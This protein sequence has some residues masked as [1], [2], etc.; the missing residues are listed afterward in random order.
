MNDTTETESPELLP[1][2]AELLARFA[3]IL[4]RDAEAAGAGAKIKVETRASHLAHEP[5]VRGVPQG[6][7][8]VAT[9]AAKLRYRGSRNE[10]LSAEDY[11]GVVS[12]A[13]GKPVR[14]ETICLP[15][16]GEPCKACQATG[17]ITHGKRDAHGVILAG[18]ARKVQCKHCNGKGRHAPTTHTAIVGE[19]CTMGRTTDDFRVSADYAA[20]FGRSYL[21]GKEKQ[22]P[23][24]LT[25]LGEARRWWETS[26]ETRFYA[27]EKIDTHPYVVKLGERIIG[28]F[29]RREHAART[30][31]SM[32]PKATLWHVGLTYRKIG[33]MD[34]LISAAGRPEHGSKVLSHR[35]VTGMS[36]QR[37]A[38]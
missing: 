2:E 11:R 16:V 36:E 8:T 20:W 25:G 35:T 23:I 30:V 13:T 33:Y 5:G 7:V 17:T 28:M 32:G 4:K 22:G 10:R 34:Q 18:K 31:A 12:A 14:T 15:S 3:A 1:G 9:E 29:A 37:I 24:A 6:A 38:A 19:P 21:K 27:A 26:R